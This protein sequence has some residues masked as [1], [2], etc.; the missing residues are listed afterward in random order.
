MATTFSNDDNLPPLPLPDLH[1]TL[2]LY[3]ETIRP[4]VNDEEYE[5]TAEIV[6][7][8]EHGQGKVLH[9]ELKER[10]NSMGNWVSILLISILLLYLLY[11]HTYVQG[12][13]KIVDI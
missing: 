6:R 8:F 13:S 1:D 9:E 10:A 7:E 4:H 12:V 2:S 3:L 11:V 5:K